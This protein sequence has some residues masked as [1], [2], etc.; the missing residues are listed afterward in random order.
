MVPYTTALRSEVLAAC[1]A[2]E[3]T[4]VVSLRFEDS[5]SWVRRIKQQR[6]ETGQI[7]PK[8]AVPRQPQWLAW[9][10]WLVA[11]ITAWPDIYLRELQAELKQDRGEEVGL[12]TICSACRALDQSRKKDADCPGARSS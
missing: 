11:K 4:R 10:N 3:G 9:T 8:T 7:A 12:M 2:N 1:V 5:E 6:R